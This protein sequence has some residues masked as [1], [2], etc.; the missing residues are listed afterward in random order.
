MWSAGTI[1][2]SGYQVRGQWTSDDGEQRASLEG[3]TVTGECSLA[4]ASV[5][6]DGAEMDNG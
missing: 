3:M 4:R 2:S 6:S 1:V 5:E